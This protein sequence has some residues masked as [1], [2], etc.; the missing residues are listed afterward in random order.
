MSKRDYYE[1][2]GISKNASK[3]EIKKAYKQLAK[4]Y[5]PDINKENDGEK[6]K[7]ISEAY[8][9]LSDDNKKAQYDQY[10]HAGF[11]QR[12]SQEDIFRGTDFSDVFDDVF[13]SNEFG[14]SIFDMFFG[15]RQ[16]QDAGGADLRYDLELDFEDAV[17]GIEKEIQVTKNE[18]CKKC[19]GSGAE[20]GKF[21]TCGECKGN[22]QVRVT[23]K[24]M[25]GI[26]TQIVECRKCNA[27][28]KIIKEYCKNCKGNG[29]EQVTK[30]LKVKIPAGVDTGS[31]IRLSGEGEPAR[32]GHAGDLYIYLFVKENDKF[33]REGDN[34][35]YDLII[36]Y[37][38]AVFGDDV[39]FEGLRKNI[40]LNIPV[41]T[42]VGTVFRLKNEGV[43]RLQ[44]S[45][46][47]DLYVKMNIDVPTK[48]TKD[49][50]KKLE[51]F[52]ELLGEKKKKKGFFNK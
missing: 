14:G 19:K 17:F 18:A 50:K 26:M 35:F 30:V 11:D 20:D 28:G 3:D 25:F 42:K 9:V 49:Q 41:G 16:R 15:G 12:F 51:E 33:K 34:L 2:L 23:R 39:E 6:F 46:A 36:S 8:A 21:E 29:I 31:R 1:I 32:S 22:G 10:G 24:T 7:E 48:L 44:K 27:T 47:G 45:G 40:K 38:Q 43:K 52:G 13:G 37:P 5:H 4:K